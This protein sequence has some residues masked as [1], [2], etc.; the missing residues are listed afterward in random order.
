MKAFATSYFGYSPLVWLPHT[1][2][3]NSKVSSLHE[4]ALR[5]KYGDKN[6]SFQSLI[7]KHTCFNIS[8]KLA[9]TKIF[10]VHNNMI[11]EI[12]NDFYKRT[13]MLCGL[14]NHNSL[15]RLPTDTALKG[16]ETSEKF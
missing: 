11:S 9:T 4:R 6:S 5:I 7:E 14:Q 15:E 13:T 2:G 10:K 1:R 12:L 3:L 16:T 8:K